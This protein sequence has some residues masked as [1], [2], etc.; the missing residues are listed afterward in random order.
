MSTA[1]SGISRS[2]VDKPSEGGFSFKRAD[3]TKKADT[4]KEFPGLNDARP[5]SFKK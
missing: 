3:G 1:E 2:K 4:Q 5:D